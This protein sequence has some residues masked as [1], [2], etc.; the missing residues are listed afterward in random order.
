MLVRSSLA[1][2]ILALTACGG[3]GGGAAIDAPGG[4]DA[5]PSQVMEVTCPATT[6][7]TFTTDDAT[8]TFSPKTASITQGQIV[9][10]VS[11]N[12]THPIIPIPGDPLADP[13]LTVPG[14][15]T[16]C[17]NFLMKGTYNFQCKIHGFV[18]ALTVN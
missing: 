13:G 4:V 14:G 2:S 10:F 7:V 18:G 15:Q 8:L 6:P 11:T 9:K 17:F 3:D 1:L 5:K 16:K 12:S